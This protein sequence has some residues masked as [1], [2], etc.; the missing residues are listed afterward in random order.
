MNLLPVS[1]G[2]WQYVPQARTAAIGAKPM[3]WRRIVAAHP[4]AEQQQQD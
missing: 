4:R 3:S 1:E 2:D